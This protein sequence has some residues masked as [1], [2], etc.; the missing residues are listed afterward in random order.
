L[1]PI[2]AY[3]WDPPAKNWPTK[4]FGALVILSANRGFWFEYGELDDLS[5]PRLI[6][7]FS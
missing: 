6:R 2:P 4:A 5:R 7:C 1:L 3:F